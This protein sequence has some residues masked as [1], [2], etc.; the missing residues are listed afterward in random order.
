MKWEYFLF[1]VRT[2]QWMILVLSWVLTPCGLIGWCQHFR[3]TCCF[4]LQG[5]SDK[6]CKYRAYIASEERRLREGSQSER[7]NMGK[8]SFYSIPSLWL[9]PFPQLLLLRSYISLLPCLVTSALKWRQHVSP[10]CWHQ[11]T[12]PHSA[13][14]QDNNIAV[15][16]LNIIC[17]RDELKQN[18]L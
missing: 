3:E 5:W 17:L 13:R 9:A 11:P 18:V 12:K 7:R 6:V 8:G 4:H 2:F 1:M 16:T 15:R 14:T 10:K